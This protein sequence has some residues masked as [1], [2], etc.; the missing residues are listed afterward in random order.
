MNDLTPIEERFRMANPIPDPA[1]PP[2][3]APTAATALLEL[4]ERR[5]T[6]QTEQMPKPATTPSRDRK[7]TITAGI[8]AA[9]VVVAA[10]LALWFGWLGNGGSGD[11]AELPVADGSVAADPTITFNEA[12]LTCSYDGPTEFPLG[13]DAT[14]TVVNDSAV[15]VDFGVGALKP[16]L[17]F[18]D[19]RDAPYNWQL[20]EL[21][22]E[23]GVLFPDDGADP[24]FSRMARGIREGTVPDHAGTWLIRCGTLPIS[25]GPDFEH[26]VTTFEVVPSG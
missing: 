24:T 10:A 14:F 23:T 21:S 7:R 13:V 9:A 19:A 18:E 20:F 2:A 22:T 1:N 5:G 6:M 26:A 16:G 12:T 15:P 17:G 3:M 25:G 8:V 11:G 4:E